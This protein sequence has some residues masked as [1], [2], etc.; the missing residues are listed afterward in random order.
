MKLRFKKLDSRAILP[1]RA[2]PGSAGL[3][4]CASIRDTWSLYEDFDP[5][6][7]V[8]IFMTRRVG[9]FI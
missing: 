7:V 1:V 3:D 9:R 8:G 4:L 5:A 2:T 6:G